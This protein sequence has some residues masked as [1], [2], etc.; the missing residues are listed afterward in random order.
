MADTKISA[1]S[2]LTGA[3]VATGDLFTLVDVSDTTMAGSG[4][5]KSITAAEL[6]NFL[7]RFGMPQLAVGTTQETNSSNTTWDD[8]TAV[9]WSV[10][11]G[12]VYHV[13][14]MGVFQT[15]ATTTG[16]QMRLNGATASWAVTRA[17]VRQAANGTDSWY[18]TGSADMT[19]NAANTAVVAANTDYVFMFECMLTASSTATL[20]F[21]YRSEINASQVTVQSGVH[22]ILMDVT[23]T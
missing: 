17:S 13:K 18:E 9:G 23:G 7:E 4:T 2:A 6:V 21:Q 3:N 16:M 15:A 22:G 12:R 5:N 1:L 20:Q 10:T 11:S 14:I 8:V 19:Q